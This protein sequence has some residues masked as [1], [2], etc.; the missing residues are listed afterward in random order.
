MLGSKPVW[1]SYRARRSEAM[2][3]FSL[4]NAVAGLT[5]AIEVGRAGSRRGARRM[6]QS[7]GAGKV[8]A[9]SGS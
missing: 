1:E 5:K 3:E 7:A 4:D 2:A 8:G 9:A 6:A